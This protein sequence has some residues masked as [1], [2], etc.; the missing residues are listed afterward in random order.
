MRLRPL[1]ALV[2]AVAVVALLG[3]GLVA[4]NKNSIAV[5]D[6]APTAALPL[7]EGSGTADVSDFRGQWVLLNFW[8]SW[9]EPCQVESP[10]IEKW[11]NDHRGAVKVLGVNTEDLTGDATDFVH[12]YGLTWEMVRDGE[13]KFK[14][15]YGI[16]ALPESFLIDPQGKL[17]LIQRGTVNRKFLD[18]A[19]TPLIEGK[20]A[21]A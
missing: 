4:K 13:G 15:Q 20:G 5:G 1:L 12:E 21:P 10:T 16:Y 19:V 3:Y 7:L 17:A 9:C 6:P 2:A 11:A 18:E 14:D 8:A